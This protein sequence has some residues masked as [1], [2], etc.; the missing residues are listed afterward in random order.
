MTDSIRLAKRLAA[1]VS[2]SRSDAEHYI[3]AGWVRV[4]G[5]VELVAES[6]VGDSQ[7]VELDAHATLKPAA[8]VTILLHQPA[9]HAGDAAAE[10]SGGDPAMEYL[11]SAAR[12]SDDR[13]GIRVLKSHFMHLKPVAP[14]EKGASGLVVFTQ[15][16]RIA[17]KLTQDAGGIEREVIVEVEGEIAEHG[18]KRLN[19]GLE[20]N[21]KALPPIKASW[22][23]ERRLRFALKGERPGQIVH[24][25]TSVG[26]KV[27][28]MK[29][30]R[31]G[32][33]PMAGLAP[34]QWRY[35]P[36]GER[37]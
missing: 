23:N 31:I 29:R 5:R 18:L 24:M 22:Q 3:S 26:L 36:D 1:Q 27:L 35:L 8:P 17:R 28:G 25:C 6:R 32:R 2:C 20:W 15:D 33:V 16:G 37:F 34:G 13:S 14:L 10:A 11:K 19:H 4:D 12:A 7:K 30:I 9:A 21:G